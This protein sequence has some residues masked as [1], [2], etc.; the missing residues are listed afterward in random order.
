MAGPQSTTQE[1]EVE[2]STLAPEESKSAD[3][4][5]IKKLV[6][7]FG[8]VLVNVS[9]LSPLIYWKMI[10]KNITALLSAKI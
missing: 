4:D 3:V 10:W 1:N 2:E 5:E 6:K 9:L 7:D 8:R